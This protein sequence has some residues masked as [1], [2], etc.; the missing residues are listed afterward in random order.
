MASPIA[1]AYSQ[2]DR[3][4]N[5]YLGHALPSLTFP[6]LAIQA[7]PDYARHWPMWRTVRDC[8]EGEVTVKAQGQLYLRKL[9]AH[10]DQE[11]EAFLSR[12]YFYNATRRTHEGLMGSLFRKPPEFTMPPPAQ[13]VPLDD[14]TLDGQSAAEFMRTMAS[15]I[16]LTGRYG[17]LTDL[18][19]EDGDLQP[20][21]DRPYISGYTA[22]CI[23]SW[24]EVVHRG[25][26]ICDRVV[27]RENETQ[28]NEY[29]VT[30]T[31]VIRV[32]RLDP[33][34][35]Q[36]D[37]LVYSQEIIRPSSDPEQPPHVVSVPV[38]VR[39]RRLDYIPFVFV[40]ARNLLPAADAPPLTDI[41]TI[42]I[43]HYQSTALL[44]HGRFYAGMP[45]YVVSAGTAGAP[46]VSG[47]DALA[48]GPSN[49]WELE[50]G[51]KAWILEFNGHGLSFLENAVDSKQL[52]MQ[53]LGGKLI[54]SQRKAAALSSE[55]YD[56][57]EQG[58][59]ATLLDIA[60]QTERGMARALEHLADFR[61]VQL[62][63]APTE[64]PQGNVINNRVVVEM[65]K[66]FVRTDLTAR[67]LR[68]IQSLY[69][70]GL[71]PLDVLYYALR[72]VNVVPIEYTLEDFKALLGTPGQQYADPTG[73]EARRDVLQNKVEVARIAAHVDE[74]AIAPPA[75]NGSGAFNNPPNGAP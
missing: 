30:V 1:A 25:R 31:P 34:P 68:A 49:V 3:A 16:V 42:N 41:A 70:S 14:V 15:E 35:E 6:G 67:E 65:N 2:V 26:R 59:E 74:P 37:R 29:G 18:P 33:D 47:S 22:E 44:E 63:A 53:S 17:I 58:D 56:L 61:G 55:A 60:Q 72:S 40:N 66:E 51:A 7:H 62:A 64:D 20:D 19:N 38:T 28:L 57:M 11:Y 24:R 48:V 52:Q 69:T 32:L 50:A 13:S 39:G 36:P 43:S 46:D 45:T 73:A 54:S 5:P 10:K 75:G 27:L 21:V 8:Y 12:A 9:S 4:R 71:I 23:Y